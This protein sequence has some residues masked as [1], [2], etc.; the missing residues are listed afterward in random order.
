MYINF[1]PKML[2]RLQESW[3][4]LNNGIQKR[5]VINVVFQVIILFIFSI[6]TQGQGRNNFW[7]FGDSAG[8][9]FNQSPPVP[10][11]TSVRSRGSCVSI[12]DSLGS[13][14][15]YAND[16]AGNGNNSTLVWNSQNNQM[17]NGDSIQGES[18]YNELVIIPKPG[19][20][21]LFYLF[22]GNEVYPGTEGL[23]YSLID[24]SQNSGLGAVINKN[25]QLNTGLITDCLTGIKHANGRDWWLITKNLDTNTTNA[26]Y[27]RL[28]TPDSIYSPMVQNMVGTKDYGLTKLCLTKDASHLMQ[29]N[30][31]GFMAQY[32]FD[33]CTGIISNQ[34][35]IFPE[36]FSN[37]ERY[38]LSGA[39][40]PDGRLYYAV[41]TFYSFNESKSRLIQ[42]DLNSTDIPL[43]ADTLVV[44]SLPNYLGLLK[45]APDDKIYV[46]G[47]YY[48][49]SVPNNYPYPDSVYNTINMNLSVINYPDSLGSTCDFQPYSFY[50]G[51]TR[52]YWGLP[53]NPDYE[54]VPIVGS[55]CDSLHLDVNNINIVPRRL[56]LSPNPV[57][58]FLYINVSGLKGKK[59]LVTIFNSLGEEVFSKS[60]SVF[61][62]GY[63][64]EEVDV[65]FFISGMYVVRLTTEKEIISA[66]FVK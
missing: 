52:T 58:K 29:V 34:Q 45:L 4:F 9:N 18:L 28:I 48:I 57:S 63:G 44:D 54:M 43:S 40:S 55:I 17:T 61:N 31:G 13:L 47:A 37:N 33:R 7:C 53:N 20:T 21:K 30:L 50:L 51:G 26:F 12:A 25:I 59:G 1:I 46:S 60:L 8:I 19:S 32:D 27:V 10:I 64:T 14:L 36:Q 2:R 41:T 6:P 35:I 56:L 49:P 5:I 23:Y 16:R 11:I 62:G 65:S 15:F 24:M 38:F 39:Y 66:K 22:T 42:F 3:S